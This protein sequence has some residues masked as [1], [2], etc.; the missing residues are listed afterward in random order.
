MDAIASATPH[1]DAQRVRHWVRQFADVLEMPE[2]A[3]SAERVLSHY[4]APVKQAPQ[5]KQ[6]KSK[7]KRKKEK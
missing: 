1:L 6:P 4:S 7:A 3:D 2:I 5:S